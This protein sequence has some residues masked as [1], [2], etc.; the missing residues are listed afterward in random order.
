MFSITVIGTLFPFLALLSS[1]LSVSSASTPCVVNGHNHNVDEVIT[2]DITII[3]GGSAGTYAA[4]SLQDLGKSV[5]VVEQTGRLGG[6][7]ETYT[8]PGTGATIDIGVMIF[9]NISVV[10][11]YFARLG[12]ASTIVS[13]SAG[14]PNVV[15]E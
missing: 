10:T 4:I 3:G 2:R 7:T 8:D 9:H 14:N 12:V 6:N 13:E 11:N 1:F 5:A 15:S